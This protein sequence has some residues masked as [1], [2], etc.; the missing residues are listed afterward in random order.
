MD[1]A[2]IRTRSQQLLKQQTDGQR[3]QLM[4]RLV[5]QVTQLP[6]WQ[7]SQTVALFMAQPFEI[8]TQLLVQIALQQGK[9]VTV[10]KVYPK[11]VM[12]LEQINTTTQYERSQFGVLEPVDTKAIAPEKIDFWVV[13]GL[14]F[15][16]D[17]QRVGFG[18]GYYDRVLSQ[19]AGYKLGI[20][21]RSNYYVSA[22]W[23]IDTF[24]VAMDAV[25]VVDDQENEKRG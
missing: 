11:R 7:V 13:P 23:P 6:A 18:A 24:D 1:K 14:A 19:T 8:P 2:A 15:S 17:L 5:Q 12:R 4:S 9:T 20:T 22:S 10:P 16:T 21:I 3:G 25:L